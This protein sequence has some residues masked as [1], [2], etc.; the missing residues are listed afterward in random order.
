MVIIILSNNLVARNL[1]IEVNKC[2][3]LNS[4]TNL[5]IYNI[6]WCH[7]Q[8]KDTHGD[9]IFIILG[10]RYLSKKIIIHNYVSLKLWI[11]V[12]L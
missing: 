2:K 1:S 10:L 11:D 6:M 7:Y 12:I 9:L 4:N 3:I 5:H 8:L